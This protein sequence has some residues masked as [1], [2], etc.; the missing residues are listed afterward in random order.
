M[1]LNESSRGDEMTRG[2]FYR[3]VVRAHARAPSEPERMREILARVVEEVLAEAL[4]AVEGAAR[5]LVEH[6]IEHVTGRRSLPCRF[7]LPPR[8]HSTR[9]RAARSR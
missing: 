6:E 1:A 3:I 2:P 5:V 4:P 9:R 7:R 8:R